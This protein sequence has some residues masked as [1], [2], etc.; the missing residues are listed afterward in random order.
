[1]LLR[2]NGNQALHV[3]PG[4]HMIVT[5]VAIATIVQKFDWTIVT[6]L[7]IRGFHMIVAIA[8]VF[9]VSTSKQMDIL[10]SL[11]LLLIVSLPIL[12]Q[13]DRLLKLLVIFLC[14]MKTEATQIC[15]FFVQVLHQGTVFFLLR[16]TPVT[17]FL[18]FDLASYGNIAN[19][20]L[21]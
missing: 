19:F 11:L 13:S 2:S 21:S 5:I 6:I 3:K 18:Y 14:F 17:I 20:S 15:E 12:S 10:F 9:M 7:A 4:F 1:M 8:V 16:Y